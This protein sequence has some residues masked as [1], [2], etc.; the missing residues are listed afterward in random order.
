MEDN[1]LKLNGT[2]KLLNQVKH[3]K[4][5]FRGLNRLWDVWSGHDCGAGPELGTFGIF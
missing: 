4:P 2:L 5:L 1:D 3:A